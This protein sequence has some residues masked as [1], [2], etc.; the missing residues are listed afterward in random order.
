MVDGRVPTE[1]WKFYLGK[2]GTIRALHNVTLGILVCDMMTVSL[3]GRLF[4]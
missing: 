3:M 2:T 4:R 1:K